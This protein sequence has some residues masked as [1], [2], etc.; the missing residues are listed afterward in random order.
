MFRFFGYFDGVVGREDVFGVCAYVVG[1][2]L[3]VFGL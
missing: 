2:V 3:V 1:V